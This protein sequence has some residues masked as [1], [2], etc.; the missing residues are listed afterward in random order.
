MKE[1]YR[2]PW[3]PVSVTLFKLC[4]TCTASIFHTQ[5]STVPQGHPEQT[6][7]TESSLNPP[8]NVPVSSSLQ[9]KAER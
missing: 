3:E 2:A 1:K 5:I 6:W 4:M 9:W 7:E 8:I